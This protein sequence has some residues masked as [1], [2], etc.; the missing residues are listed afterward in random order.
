MRL[1]TDEAQI[2]PSQSFPERSGQMQ[3]RLSNQLARFGQEQSLASTTT[4]IGGQMKSVQTS[5]GMSQVQFG[6]NQTMLPLNQS[7]MNQ[8]PGII[9]QNPTFSQFPQQNVLGQ[10]QLQQQPQ[11]TV[12]G[13][14]Q[15]QLQ[16]FQMP[17]QQSQMVTQ[18]GPNA[19]Q[20]PQQTI[21]MGIP[22]PNI[23]QRSQQVMMQQPQ[24]IFH[25]IQNPV[26]LRSS[27]GL[28]QT[29]MS[30]GNQGI[31]QLSMV[32]Q[33]TSQP[34]GPSG[35]NSQKQMTSAGLSNV[36]RP[37]QPINQ[38][39]FGHQQQISP[40]LTTQKSHQNQRNVSDV[41]GNQIQN[42]DVAEGNK[43]AIS[44]YR[45]PKTDHHQRDNRQE[46]YN[47]S[48]QRGNKQE[49]LNGSNASNAILI[50]DDNLEPS[51]GVRDHKNKVS[52][53]GR[54][55]DSQSSGSPKMDRY[56]R[57][58][59]FGRSFDMRSDNTRRDDS[60]REDSKSKSSDHKS[61]D[62]RKNR[63]LDRRSMDESK[64]PSDTKHKD[65]RSK[66][67][68]KNKSSDSIKDEQKT[69]SATQE[70][71]K[72]YPKSSQ[73]GTKVPDK[74]AGVGKSTTF[75]EKTKSGSYI[76]IGGSSDR[77]KNTK[78]DE[79]IAG[80]ITI[81]L[82]PTDMNIRSDK[83]KQ[84][85]PLDNKGNEVEVQS[86]HSD[87]QVGKSETKSKVEEKTSKKRPPQK[88][89][90]MEKPSIEKNK[91]VKSQTEGKS[92]IIVDRQDTDDVSK[93]EI[94]IKKGK[95]TT[96]LSVTDKLSCTVT[97]DLIDIAKVSTGTLMKQNTDNKQPAIASSSTKK[98]VDSNN[99]DK[100]KASNVSK[101]EVFKLGSS[102]KDKRTEMSA[103]ENK[104]PESKETGHKEDKNKAD[105]VEVILSSNQRR[106]FQQKTEEASE[107]S[108]K[109]DAR[110]T[111]VIHKAESVEVDL[112]DE[113]AVTD[114]WREDEPMDISE[115]SKGKELSN[116][117]SKTEELVSV[118]SVTFE[119]EGESSYLKPSGE[120]KG[121][122]D[123][124]IIT[125]EVQP[126]RSST[127]KK[128]KESEKNNDTEESMDFKVTDEFIDAEDENNEYSEDDD[129]FLDLS[130]FVTLD[131]EGEVDEQ[132]DE[133]KATGYLPKK[134]ESYSETKTSSG[135]RDG[136][137]KDNSS[138]RR[139][140]SRDRDSQQRKTR[141]RSKEGS[142]KGSTKR[143]GSRSR[144]SARSDRSKSKD[145]ESPRR[146]RSR[147]K[148]SQSRKSQSTGDSK[149]SH[150]Q[151]GVVINVCS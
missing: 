142:R 19:I 4:A 52:S 53:Y 55:R 132:T 6:Q 51:S 25:G 67:K 83:E 92:E 98:A 134:Y 65:E 29:V 35:F 77:N 3:S 22:N 44:K 99:L 121:K 14:Q 144:R 69:K 79:R 146:D 107:M 112:P 73:Q 111:V 54:P 119:M 13:Q 118:V 74:T 106:N 36:Q 49:T 68:G 90:E 130:Q 115:N 122:R 57:T 87:K 31:N 61:G 91:T 105:N 45:I 148:G 21:Q 9:Q 64:K 46:E 95:G 78:K 33:H 140:R 70:E 15:P 2:T 97:V 11:R 39:Q 100:T 137:Q 24:Q 47:N 117:D 135:A 145:K 62:V 128:K 50:D 96:P 149:T 133:A 104:T 85:I 60:K 116:Q 7:L 108:S 12:L 18:M 101:K 8:K 151:V 109:R 80:N 82:I 147:S 126:E 20:V 16:Q 127:N 124:N 129:E 136:K 40:H 1:E 59:R 141:S 150:E 89:S 17:L 143:D 94:K 23:G 76:E 26:Q 72:A 123:E 113:W 41:R 102:V 75:P 27:A 63:S 84:D 81:E 114:E 131:E 37:S 5:Q 120:Q 32:Q 10:Q 88:S 139:Q 86:V 42:F 66:S 56:S 43:S 28:N 125:A 48:R 103:D 38:K 58:D 138:S 71:N 93:S 30:I 34:R 110:S